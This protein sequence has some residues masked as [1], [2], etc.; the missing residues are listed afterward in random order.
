MP[1]SHGVEASEW[2]LVL[3]CHKFVLRLIRW[4]QGQ[5]GRVRA[6]S[7][8]MVTRTDVIEFVTWRSGR[9]GRSAGSIITG[10]VRFFDKKGVALS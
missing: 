8:A 4:Q 2:T 9:I 7:R 5:R 1:W 6:M 3:L 10:N